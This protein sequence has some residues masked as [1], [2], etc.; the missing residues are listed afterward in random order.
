VEGG[1]PIGGRSSTNSDGFGG[2]INVAAGTTMLS[3]EILASGRTFGELSV[4]VRPNSVVQTRIVA[5]G[6]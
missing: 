2:L 6:Q 4:F 5:A 1:V 3:G